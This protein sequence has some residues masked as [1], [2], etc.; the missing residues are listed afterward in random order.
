MMSWWL[1]VIMHSGFI[2]TLLRCNRHISGS[3][4][5]CSAFSSNFSTDLCQISSEHQIDLWEHFN[6]NYKKCKSIAAL[7]CR[8][9]FFI[10][11]IFIIGKEDVSS[12]DN[13]AHTWHKCALL[14]CISQSWPQY[15]LYANLF[16]HFIS[17]VPLCAGYLALCGCLFTSA[18]VIILGN[19][20]KHLVNVEVNVQ[21]SYPC[22]SFFVLWVNIHEG[23]GFTPN[24]CVGKE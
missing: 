14:L 5:C 1:T 18:L 3:C 19:Q 15:N 20:I 4:W 10:G 6:F 13:S 11:C 17:E 12:R 21:S 2:V 24:N 23:G 22:R 16:R 9:I 7:C 8:T